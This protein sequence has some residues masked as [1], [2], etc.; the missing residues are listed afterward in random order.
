M[1]ALTLLTTRY[2][3]PRLTEPAPA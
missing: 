2:S 3:T 1:D